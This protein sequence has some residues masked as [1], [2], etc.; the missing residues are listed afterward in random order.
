[1]NFHFKDL[2][3]QIIEMQR[4]KT[5]DDYYSHFFDNF[6]EICLILPP[7]SHHADCCTVLLIDVF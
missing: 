6:N 1:M 2:I 7:G 5:K 4:K 3:F